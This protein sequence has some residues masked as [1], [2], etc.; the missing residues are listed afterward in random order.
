VNYDYSEDSVVI[1]AFQGERFFREAV[2]T[3]FDQGH[4]GDKKKRTR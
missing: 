1:S 4:H 2:E 3:I